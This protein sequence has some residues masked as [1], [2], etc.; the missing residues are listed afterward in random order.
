MH[1]RKAFS[2]IVIDVVNIP[3]NII[4]DILDAF[5]L[6]GIRQNDFNGGFDEAIK[7]IQF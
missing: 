2:F 1:P 3:K 4:N 5:M 6:K 7:T